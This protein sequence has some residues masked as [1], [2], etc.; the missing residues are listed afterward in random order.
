M[1]QAELSW[2]KARSDTSRIPLFRSDGWLAALDPAAA[3]LHARLAMNQLRTTKDEASRI[4]ALRDGRQSLQHALM[5]QPQWPYTWISLA[6]TEQHLNPSGSRW[7][8]ATA[9][10]IE[11]GDRGIAFQS[12]LL[13]LYR[14]SERFIDPSTRTLMQQSL[15]NHLGADIDRDPWLLI[16]AADAVS[17]ICVDPQTA[18]F[19]AHCEPDAP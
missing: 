11:L 17:A 10:A 6:Q 5:L 15:S 7:R 13:A 2:L 8:A 14:Q 19:R 16:E 1:Q 3:E 18:R 12:S 4:A 9:T